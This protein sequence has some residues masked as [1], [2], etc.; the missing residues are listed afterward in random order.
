[1]RF[2]AC[3]RMHSHAGAWERG[4]GAALIFPVMV[5]PFFLWERLSAA[6]IAPGVGAD[7]LSFAPSRLRVRQ[8]F[9]SALPSPLKLRGD[10]GGLCA[11]AASG[12]CLKW[13]FF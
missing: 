11:F 5:Q 6:K 10:R 8:G 1:M 2:P 13:G 12:A 9:R 7:M 3:L 4:N